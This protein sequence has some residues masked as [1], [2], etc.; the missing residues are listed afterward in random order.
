MPTSC[1]GREAA[2]RR[3][4]IRPWAMPDD[5]QHRADVLARL[6]GKLAEHAAKMAERGLVWRPVVP[7]GADVEHRPGGPGLAAD[8]ERERLG[9][10]PDGRDV[11]ELRCRR[12]YA[13]RWYVGRAGFV[14]EEPDAASGATAG[15]TAA[16]KNL[17]RNLDSDYAKAAR[18]AA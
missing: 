9:P 5:D 7:D 14:P 16:K 4:W 1:R 11:W 6:D 18:R 17:L 10:K 2:W 12:C 13:R 8:L 3:P 15:R